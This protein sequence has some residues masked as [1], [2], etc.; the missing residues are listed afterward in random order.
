MP[1]VQEI[2]D[3]IVYVCSFYLPGQIYGHFFN[4]TLTTDEVKT[5]VA[6]HIKSRGGVLYGDTIDREAVR[7]RLLSDKGF[8]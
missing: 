8:L 4:H 2:N 5:A 6:W 1:S 7:D 3:F